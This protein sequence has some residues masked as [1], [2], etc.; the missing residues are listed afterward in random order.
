VMPRSEGYYYPSWSPDGKYLVAMAEN[1]ARMALYS[2]ATKTW[3]DLHAF[4]EQWGFWSWATDSNSLYM[5]VFLGKASDGIYRVTIPQGGWEKLSGVEGINPAGGTESFV[6]IT[7][8]GQ[9]AVMSRT[10]AAQIYL[11]HWPQ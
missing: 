1:P 10:G 7:R 9:P 4:P 8:D 2:T 11:L 3:K 5:A 6:S